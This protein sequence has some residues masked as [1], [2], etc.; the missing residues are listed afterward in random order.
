MILGTHN[1][2]TSKSKSS[3]L[4]TSFIWIQWI[5]N[6]R[7]TD[8]ITA[9]FGGQN[10]L[11]N[12]ALGDH[13][14]HTPQKYL[15]YACELSFKPCMIL[16]FILSEGKNNK[17]WQ[18]SSLLLINRKFVNIIMANTVIGSWVYASVLYPVNPKQLVIL[19]MRKPITRFHNSCTIVAN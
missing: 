14:L 4:K 18:K 10:G 7:H 12:I 1:L 3:E 8:L 2:H 16:K 13:N 6:K 11:E 9:L 5:Q 19:W 17:I 15:W